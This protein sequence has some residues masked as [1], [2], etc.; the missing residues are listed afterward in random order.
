MFKYLSDNIENGHERDFNTLERQEVY[1]ASYK[2][3]NDPYDN[4]ETFLLKDLLNEMPNRNAKIL[5]SNF[6]RDA[7]QQGVYCLS[8]DHQSSVMWQHYA[9]GWRGLCIEFSEKTLKGLCERFRE[10]H[11]IK[12]VIGVA[13]MK[14]REKIERVKIEDFK[15][16][17]GMEDKIKLIEKIFS[18]KHSSWGYESEVRMFFRQEGL[19][20]V[21]GNLIKKVYL[22]Y[23]M[24]EERKIKY[25]KMLNEKSIP[26]YEAKFDQM[27]FGKVTAKL[28]TTDS[29]SS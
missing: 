21:P 24:D 22:G 20:K 18:T 16:M 26:V 1:A 14:Y 3:L 19:Y 12:D 9:N 29:L 15:K 10:E 4:P 17:N 23:R 13:K 5:L 6:I 11:S 7:S 28:L 2:N 25:L 8:T 27:G